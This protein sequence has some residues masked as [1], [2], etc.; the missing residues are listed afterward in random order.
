MK[1]MVKQTAVAALAGVMAAG[2]LSGCGEKALD[3]TKTVAMVNGAEIPMGILSLYTRQQQAQVEAMY[4]S[5]MGEGAAIWDQA[6]SDDSDKTYGQEFAEGALEQ[7]EIMYLAKEKAGDYGVE[8]TEEDET[9]I[10]EAAAAFMENNSE[11]T[12]AELAVSEDQVKEYLELQTYLEG[13]HSAVLE[14][15][16]IQV[17]DEE[18]QQAKFTY[19]LVS[20]SDESLTEDDIAEKKEQAQEILDKM[21]EDPD[22]DVDEMVDAVDE[23]Y[24]ALSGYY[25]ANETEADDV[26]S[27]TYPEEVLEVLR[28]LDEGEVAP[29]VV[30]T[31]N[32]YYAL[33]LDSTNDEE[34]TESR[35]ESLKSTRETEVYTETTT[36]WLEE[37]D[38]QVDEEVLNT[39]EI[40]D[41]HSFTYDTSSAAEADEEME[42]AEVIADEDFDEIEL[43]DE[44]EVID[45][46]DESNVTVAEDDMDEIEDTEDNDQEVIEEELP[47]EADATV[48]DDMDETADAEDASTAEE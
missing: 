8:V 28:G 34:A 1:R 19:V 31:E 46:M 9:A 25:S 38:I 6:A 16:D 40:T 23:S 39:L 26:A 7:I 12:I 5:F 2:L 20:T 3:G 42:D 36:Q 41:S 18:A 48:V 32:G 10:A 13:V 27:T 45:D 47:E 37:A 15:A 24:S 4:L 29:E 30:E 44:I 35:K 33:R 43:D 17:T 21:T 22:G 11:E 14:E